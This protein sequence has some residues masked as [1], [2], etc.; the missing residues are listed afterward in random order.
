MNTKYKQLEIVVATKNR[1]DQIAR[2]LQS[3]SNSSRIPAKIIIVYHGSILKSQ[4]LLSNPSLNLQFI[5]SE[6]A[7][8]IFQKKLGLKALSQDCE[9]VFFLDDDV[10]IETN[11]LDKLFELYVANNAVGNY[12]GFGL[13]IK[14]RPMQHHNTAVNF[15]LYLVKLYSLSSQ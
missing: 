7:S 11:T 9:W 15:L 14:N 13:A 8:Q 12:A 10:V 5:Q 2:L 3:I 4:L 6:I 1:P